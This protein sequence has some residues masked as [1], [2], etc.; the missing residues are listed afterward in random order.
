[1]GVGGS[2]VSDESV[3]SMLNK[4]HGRPLWMFPYSRGKYFGV[5]CQ[6]SVRSN[7]KNM[8]ALRTS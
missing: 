6:N 2:G 3:A 7:N 5:Y 8:Q 1:M 4:N